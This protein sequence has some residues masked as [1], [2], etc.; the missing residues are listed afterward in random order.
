M[1]SFSVEG[2]FAYA[3][4]TFCAGV[5]QSYQGQRF[6]D[7][8]APLL[9]QDPLEDFKKFNPRDTIFQEYDP[10]PGDEDKM[11]WKKS[12]PAKWWMS[13]WKAAKYV[14]CIQ[15]LGGL[16]LG[17]LA[18]LILILDFNFVDL[19]FD[20]QHGHWN[21][22]PPNIQAII[23]TGECLQAYVVQMWTFLLIVTM[24][25]WHLVKKLDS[26]ILNLLGAFCDTCYRLYLQVCDMY[27][28]SWMSFPLNA[29][30][31]IL[32]LMNS[33]LVGREIAE[34][35]V[36]LKDQGNV[37]K[38]SKYLLYWQLSWALGCL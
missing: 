18:I 11:A 2:L 29:L 30:F 34:N 24:F 17:L 32:V 1:A 21:S 31:L 16:A 13:L 15:I 27:E 6:L 7:D 23:M 8:D 28:K 10:P 3:T 36:K 4:E 20:R 25:G 38:L 19:C 26:L 33:V 9:R 35:R 14:F 37:R 12:R 22:L 5:I